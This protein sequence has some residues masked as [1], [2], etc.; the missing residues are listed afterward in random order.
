[1]LTGK[2]IF[3]AYLR[4]ATTGLLRAVRSGFSLWRAVA[5]DVV[6]PCIGSRCNSLV[7]ELQQ[8]CCLSVSPGASPLGCFPGVLSSLAPR[9]IFFFFLGHIVE[10]YCRRS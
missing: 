2:F 9:V 7:N 4:W 8:V 5:A 1:M 10:D 6:N 3:A